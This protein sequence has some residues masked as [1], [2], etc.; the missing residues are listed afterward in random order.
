MLRYEILLLI[1][2]L[3]LL[4]ETLNENAQPSRRVFRKALDPRVAKVPLNS[5][6]HFPSICSEDGVAGRKRRSSFE[7]NAYM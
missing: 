2:L 4:P 5:K 6:K 1:S 7:G 3:L